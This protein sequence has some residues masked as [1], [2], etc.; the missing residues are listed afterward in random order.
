MSHHD[1]E[2]SAFLACLASAGINIERV[3]TP[4]VAPFERNLPFR[5]PPLFRELISQYAFDPF[6]WQGVRFFGNRGT[7][8]DSDLVVASVR[9]P[10]IARVSQAH[11]F[12]QVGR[13]ENGSYDPVCFDGRH[14]S[15][16]G[17]APLVR[18]DH[19][20]V[21][22]HE[23]IRVVHQY[24]NSFAAFVGQHAAQPTP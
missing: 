7:G 22:I 6:E 24:A 14:R 5:L 17:D 11:G 2:L 3:E 21:L 12:I 15:K 8:H 19:E 1:Q 23:Q 9:D 4:W 16:S 13:P 18:I 20:A 10:I